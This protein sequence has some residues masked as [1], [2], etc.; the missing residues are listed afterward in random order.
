M[1]HRDNDPEAGLLELPDKIKGKD[2]IQPHQTREVRLQQIKLG[3]MISMTFVVFLIELFYGYFSNSI[4][5]I[6][7]AFHMLS[8]VLALSV[9]LAC[10][11]VRNIRVFVLDS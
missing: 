2:G 1:Q 9:A 4:A 11:L 6:A 10:I 5:L 8:D 3:I 7:D